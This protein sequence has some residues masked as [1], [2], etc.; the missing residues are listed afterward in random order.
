M[1]DDKKSC[2][3]PA[4]AA[5]RPHLRQRECI[6]SRNIGD[7]IMSENIENLVLEHLKRFQTVQDRIEH[8]LDEHT[9]RLGRIEMAVSG[10]KRDIAYNDETQAEQ[11]VRID[12]LAERIDRIE[13]RLELKG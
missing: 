5:S 10:I 8:K 1:N 9:L 2:D 6:I 13:R 7:G 3:F 11:S 12:H 4:A